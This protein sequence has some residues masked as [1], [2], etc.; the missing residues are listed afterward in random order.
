M[1]IRDSNEVFFW[2]EDTLRLR[3]WYSDCI[4]ISSEALDGIVASRKEQEAFEEEERKALEDKAEEEEKKVRKA[5]QMWAFKTDDSILPKVISIVCNLDRL[6]VF[7]SD[8][9]RKVPTSKLEEI[10]ETYNKVM[11]G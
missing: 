9:F 3:K 4:G 7:K 10:K 1:C 2:V 8:D 11:K 6:D 5:F